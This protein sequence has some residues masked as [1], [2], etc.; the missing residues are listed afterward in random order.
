MIPE[1]VAVNSI[2]PAIK[3]PDSEAPFLAYSFLCPLVKEGEKVKT[4]NEEQKNA[5][6]FLHG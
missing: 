5:L 3:R 6:N 1:V 4:L 2:Q